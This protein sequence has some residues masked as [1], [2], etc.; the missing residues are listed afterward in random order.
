MDRHTHSWENKV[1]GSARL[2]SHGQSRSPDAL[3]HLAIK[4][5]Y[6]AD[7]FQ[8]TEPFASALSVSTSLA[9]S[10]DGGSTEL[11]SNTA[12]KRLEDLLPRYEKFGPFDVP[13]HHR[14]HSTFCEDIASRDTT[15]IMPRRYTTTR[16]PGTTQD[17]GSENGS[18]D[19]EEVIGQ[20][21]G[22]LYELGEALLSGCDSHSTWA[23][24]SVGP[25]ITLLNP[26]NSPTMV[27]TPPN[28]RHANR[29]VTKSSS[30]SA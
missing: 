24:R 29:R 15:T 6:N 28:G 16:G 25:I 1:V 13:Q 23:K 8:F 7:F 14:S 2:I 17:T 26:A 30:S 21:D 4:C 20:G 11:P 19:D 12:P 3:R 9:R 5:H 27:T 18:C 22:A 10:H